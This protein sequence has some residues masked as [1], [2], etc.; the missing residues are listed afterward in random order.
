MIRYD[1]KFKT[2]AKNNTSQWK[3]IRFLYEHG[4]FFQ[5]VY[6]QDTRGIKRRVRYPYDLQEAKEF[7]IKYKDQAIQLRK[8]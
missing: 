7:A 8:Q 5:H 2:P 6:K 4:F 1:H 3:K